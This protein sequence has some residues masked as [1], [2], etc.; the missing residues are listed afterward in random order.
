MISTT[1]VPITTV[2]RSLAAGKRRRV[3]PLIYPAC[4][5]SQWATA[6][7]GLFADDTLHQVGRA[8][9]LRPRCCRLFIDIEH[10]ACPNGTNCTAHV[11]GSTATHTHTH[12]HT[13]T[14]TLSCWKIVLL[15]HHLLAKWDHGCHGH[16]DIVSTRPPNVSP[17]LS[18]KY[19]R[20]ILFAI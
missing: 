4:N 1:A 20:G 3:V 11:L 12:S 2:H 15:Q 18:T 19:S 14:H 16:S 6:F 17:L 13:H 5:S 7:R 8:L 10:V 9:R